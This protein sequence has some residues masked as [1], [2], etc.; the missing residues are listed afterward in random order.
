[1]VG[2]WITDLQRMKQRQ[3]PF[4]P[5]TALWERVFAHRNILHDPAIPVSRGVNGSNGLREFIDG[6][7]CQPLSDRGRGT[8][9]NPRPL[10]SQEEAS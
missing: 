7:L 5:G 1:M 2:C 4:S 3:A 9:R 6:R 8:K 10:L